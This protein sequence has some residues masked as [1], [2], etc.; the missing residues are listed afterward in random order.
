MLRSRTDK[1]R[2]QLLSV[3]E[4]TRRVPLNML[5]ETFLDDAQ[6]MVNS[7]KNAEPSAF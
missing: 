4:L 1:L 6:H 2:E 3:R 7:W 5:A